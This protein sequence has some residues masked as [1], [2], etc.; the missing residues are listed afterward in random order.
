MNAEILSVFTRIFIS[1]QAYIEKMKEKEVVDC[2]KQTDEI[3]SVYFP[4]L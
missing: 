4:L 1:I 2:T 3:Y